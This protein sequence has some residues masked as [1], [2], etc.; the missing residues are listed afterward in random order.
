MSKALQNEIKDTIQ[1]NENS[2][3]IKIKH[4]LVDR[5]KI[6]VIKRSNSIRFG[7]GNNQS[8]NNKSSLYKITIKGL[9]QSSYIKIKHLYKQNQQALK[10]VSKYNNNKRR[11][12]GVCISKTAM[13]NIKLI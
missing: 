6:I 13:S 7:L 2:S 9:I 12:V 5:F 1:T 4:L 11:I 10:I 8:I 3:Y